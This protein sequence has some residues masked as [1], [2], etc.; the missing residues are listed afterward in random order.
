MRET[1]EGRNFS[2]ETFSKPG[3]VKGVI[4][5]EVGG[6]AWDD[7]SLSTLYLRLENEVSRCPPHEFS[8]SRQTKRRRPSSN[9]RSSETI[10][11]ALRQGESQKLNSLA[12]LRVQNTNAERSS[13]RGRDRRNVSNISPKPQDIVHLE[14]ILQFLL[15]RY[16]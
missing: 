8:F 13:P 9:N 4:L 3:C 5:S 15:S 10:E 12:S 14:D 6:L 16:I 2:I 1:R 7:L 11:E